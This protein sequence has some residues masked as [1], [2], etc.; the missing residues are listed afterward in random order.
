MNID[1]NQNVSISKVNQTLSKAA[2]V[3]LA[4]ASEE[5]E[6]AISSN[7]FGGTEQTKMKYYVVSDIHGYFSLLKEMLQTN[8]FFDDSVPHKLIVCGDL[9]DRGSEVCELQDFILELMAK[10]ELILIRGNHEDLLLQMLEDMECGMSVLYTHHDANRTVATVQRLVKKGRGSFETEPDIIVARMRRTPLVRTIIPSMINCFETQHYVFVHGW[11][12]CE[13]IKTNG[14]PY[15]Y[16]PHPDWRNAT[17]EDWDYARWTNG[18]E[19][20]HQGI[21]EETKTIV[22]GHWHCSFGHANYEG[23]GNE[24]GDYADFSPYY[25]KGIIA[26]DACTAYSNRMNCLV[27]EDEPIE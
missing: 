16:S 10:D 13:V 18:M 25:A 21:T 9:F 22:C 1:T 11:I 14:K 19:A 2:R 7:G 12:P 4:V 3:G 17:E 15:R 5:M 24:F 23:N 8:G 26:I 27:L 6:Y 20:A